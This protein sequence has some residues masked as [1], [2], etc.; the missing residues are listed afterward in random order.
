MG[1]VRYYC[2]G[3][4]HKRVTNSTVLNL[5]YCSKTYFSIRNRKKISFN[6]AFWEF[7]VLNIVTCATRTL[8]ELLYQCKG[9]LRRALNLEFLQ[10]SSLLWTTAIW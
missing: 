6:A 4:V 8:Y 1:A 10:S 7:K 3:L 9:D 5:P 2:I